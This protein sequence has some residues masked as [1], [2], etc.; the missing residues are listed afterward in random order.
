MLARRLGGRIALATGLALIG[1][2]LTVKQAMDGQPYFINMMVL[3]V[4]LAVFGHQICEILRRFARVS[5]QLVGGKAEDV[6]LSLERSDQGFIIRVRSAL[7]FSVSERDVFEIYFADRASG[8]LFDEKMLE[9]PLVLP[10]IYGFDPSDPLI[11]RTPKGLLWLENHDGERTD[12]AAALLLQAYSYYRNNRDEDAITA[13]NKSVAVNPKYIDA[14][15]LRGYCKQRLGRIEEAVADFTEVLHERAQCLAAVHDMSASYLARA[16]A[17]MLIDEF[18]KA[19]NDIDTAIQ[20]TPDREDLYYVRATAYDRL[21]NSAAAV[22]DYTRYLDLSQATITPQ[23]KAAVLV[24]RAMGQPTEEAA[25][26]DLDESIRLLPTA[27]AYYFR[28]CIHAHQDRPTDVIEQ[29]TRALE[30]DGQFREALELRSETYA[31]SGNPSAAQRDIVQ[32][33]DLKATRK[34]TRS[35]EE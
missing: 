5:Q 13:L 28:A 27:T 20:L 11:V 22:A 21:S 2:P 18:A 26:K 23:E 24:Y 6:E 34:K 31:N 30:L 16:S 19:V 25:L 33:A 8:R 14:L 9:Q 7:D 12:E 32:L 29:C 35:D 15:E 10:A 3:L 1:L 17:Y 4:L